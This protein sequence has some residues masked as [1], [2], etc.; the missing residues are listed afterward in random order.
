MTKTNIKFGTDGW[1]A[2]IGKDFTP[3]NVA[4]VIQGFCDF[5]KTSANRLIYV[6]YDRRQESDA[7]AWQVASILA[8]N[9]FSVRLSSQYC[10]T[11]CISW[12]VKEKKA[13]AG[14]IVTASHNPPEW[15]GI[16]FKES[17][18]GAASPEYTD[19]IEKRIPGKILTGPFDAFL[20]SQTIQ[21]FDPK[22]TY[23]KHLQDFMDIE[24]IRRQDYQIVCDPLYGA[25]TDFFSATL[26]VDVI[27]IHDAADTSFGGLNP[28]P[29]E[30]NLSLLKE[31]V[32][33]TKA[34]IGLATD[35]D[36]D[37]IGAFTHE[38]EFVN[39]HQIFSLLLLHNVGYRKLK[40]DIVRSVSTTQLIDKICADFG[41]N[42]VET[43]IGFKHISKELLKRNAMM[44]GEESGGIS[45]REHVHERDGVFNGLSLLEMMA[46]NRKSLAELIAD[47]DQKY[48]RF[49]FARD[50]YHLTMEKIE[51]IKNVLAQDDVKEVGGVQVKRFNK[52]DGCK[53]IFED[54]SW[55]LIRPSGTEPLLRV[56]SEAKSNERVK[57]LLTF[58]KVHFGL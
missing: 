40:G 26:G 41:L 24:S 45:L 57:A 55:L 48:G 23:V 37:R 44:G 42:V 30:K 38:G 22:Q 58:A 9:G 6:G 14:V 31:T 34:D 21:F 3:E 54:D 19:E 29:I 46:V 49:Y 43:P 4:L 11:P 16:K 27:Q 17:Y 25:A 33:K 35:G 18:G 36:A 51:E 52:I 28:E 56:Y 2:I 8:A 5:K 53:M 7:T 39:S 32:L 10:P 47:M 13:L 1:R 20:D 15:N 50:D 12:L